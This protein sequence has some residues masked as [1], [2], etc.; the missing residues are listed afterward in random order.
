MDDHHDR[1][2]S[3]YA[4]VDE[5]DNDLKGIKE[6]AN[7]FTRSVEEIKQRADAIQSYNQKSI[8]NEISN[9]KFKIKFLLNFFSNQK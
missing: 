7:D 3:V 1:I 6:T 5:A 8:M 9:S 2:N 4:T